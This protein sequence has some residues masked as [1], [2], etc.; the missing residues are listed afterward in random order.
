LEELQRNAAAKEKDDH[1][2]RQ[3]PKSERL[4][5][6][7][8]NRQEGNEMF[9]A[10]NYTDAI[11]RYQKAQSHLTKM[12]DMS[13]EETAEM[14]KIL[15]SCHLNS[16]Q[17]YMKGAQSVDKENKDKAD[18]LYKKVKNSCKSALEID[19]NNLKVLYRRAAACEKLGDL[20]DAKADLTK[21]LQV[22][23]TNADCLKLDRQVER[24]LEAEK[25]K[26]KKMYGKMFG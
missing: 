16:A 2:F 4:R 12:F 26:A 13:P 8:K 14:N 6:A 21:A 9:Q 15:L 18:Q 1:D 23:S 19:E 11:V 3:L 17:C 20:Q 24:A 10:Q 25:S 5:M 7:E 22:D